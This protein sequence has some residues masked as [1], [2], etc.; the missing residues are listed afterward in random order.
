[1]QKIPVFVSSAPSFQTVPCPHY[2]G[3]RLPVQCPHAFNF[4]L[5]FS[6]ALASGTQRTFQHESGIFVLHV[7]TNRPTDHPGRDTRRKQEEKGEVA[8]LACK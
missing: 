2:R 1:M 5:L 3:R 4:F 8:S 7:E 6:F